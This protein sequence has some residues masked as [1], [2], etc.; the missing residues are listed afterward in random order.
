MSDKCPVGA[1]EADQAGRADEISPPKPDEALSALLSHDDF[2]ISVKSWTLAIVAALALAWMGGTY[3][4]RFVTNTRPPSE[5]ASPRPS[6]TEI[7]IIVER[8]IAVEST[9][10]S[11][12]KNKRSSATGAGQ[13]LDDTWIEMLQTYRRDL[14]RRRNKQQVLQLRRDSE[15][16]REIMTRLVEQN[17]AMLTKRGLPVT[18]GILYLTY[19]AGPAGAVAVLSVSD[20]AD[21]ASIMAS[22][23]ATGRTTREKLVNANPFLKALTVGDLKNWADSKMRNN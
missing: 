4:V 20:D 6:D 21:A 11:N 1:L 10:D 16:V 3:L 12:A 18:P 8:I 9:G 7:K 17:A 14:V 22:A 19:F 5:T 2:G 13:F 23:D 15:L